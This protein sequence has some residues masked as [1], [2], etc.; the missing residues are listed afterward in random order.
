MK[1]EAT[2]QYAKALQIYTDILEE[3]ET[4]AVNIQ[5]FPN[6]FLKIQFKKFICIHVACQKADHFG[7]EISEQDERIH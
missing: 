5:N 6:L 2:E 1:Y 3:D 7:L 4:N